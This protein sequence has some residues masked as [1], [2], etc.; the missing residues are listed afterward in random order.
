LDHR[1]A[2]YETVFLQSKKQSGLI[3]DLLGA[4]GYNVT[5][6]T[7]RVSNFA[8]IHVEIVPKYACS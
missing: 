8:D 7:L 6:V 3:A 1:L 4:D 2:A 5:N